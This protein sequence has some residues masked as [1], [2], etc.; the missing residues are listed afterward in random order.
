MKKNLLYR[1][2]LIVILLAAALPGFTQLNSFSDQYLGNMF[3]LNPAIAGTGRYGN[4]SLI[5]RQQWLGW[6]GAPASQSV[7]YQSKWSKSRDRFNPLG[8]INKGQNIYSNVGLGGGFFHESH[9]VFQTTGIHLDYSYHL[10]SRKGRLSFGLSPSVF[11]IGSSTIILA[12]PNDPYLQNPVKSYFVDFNAGMHY[13]TKLGYAGLSLVQLM[14]SAIKFGNYGFPEIGDPSRNPDLAR[15]AYAYAGYFF[16]INRSL[17]LK[18]EPMVLV[19]LNAINGMR[20]DV[21][22]TVHLLDKF[23]AGISYAYKRGLSVFAGVQL[24]NL[25]FRYLFE[26]PVS[27]DLPARYTSHMIQLSIN[28]G[29]PIE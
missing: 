4:L 18:I 15:S 10:Y 24:D 3:L 17:K 9:G 16:E 1:I 28:I 11:Q 22:S 19:K 21:S 12:D 23:N 7:T 20:F 26:M 2:T 27:T 14:N 25:S 6:E 29:Q 5:S 8:F 13:F